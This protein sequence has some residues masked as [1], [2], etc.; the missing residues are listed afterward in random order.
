MFL[1]LFLAHHGVCLY[2]ASANIVMRTIIIANGEPPTGDDLQTWLRDGDTLICADGG[3][4]AALAYGLLPERV[5]GDFD[6]L[7]DAELDRLAQR[8]VLLERHP[9]NKDETDLELALLHSAS[10]GSDEIVVLGAL[11]GRLD[12]TV[13]NVMLLAMPQLT[14]HKVV[15]ASGAEQTYILRPGTPCELTGHVGD[16]ISLIPFGG[17]ITGINTEGLAYPLHDEPLFFGPARGVSNVLL[18]ERATISFTSGLLLC[19]QATGQSNNL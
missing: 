13:A 18:G 17:D 4:R 2:S 5:I 11:G 10:T 14:G 12:Q 9:I 6:S 15:I 7:T 16:V 19:V 1:A 8:G 3:A